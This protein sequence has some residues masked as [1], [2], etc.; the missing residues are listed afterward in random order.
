MS[1]YSQDQNGVA[2]QPSP[3]PAGLPPADL[4][5]SAFSL[6]LGFSPA[7]G[8]SD[9]AFEAF[10]AYLELG[11]RRRYA[12]VGTK[13]GASLRT[14]K[15]WAADFNWRGRIN[16]HSAQGAA[17]SAQTE[18]AAHRGEI[19]DASARAQA[20]R[21]RQYALAEAILDVAGRYLE[22]V[23]DDDLDR[24]SFADACRALDFAS[25]L[26][27]HAGESG[28]GAAP[29]HSL[30]DQLAALLDQAC[31]EAAVPNAAASPLDHATPGQTQS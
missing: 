26:A 17:L 18:N 12:A 25:R 6:P 3:G 4:H 15:R 8:E 2:S 16:T 5:S 20:F 29:D 31:G 27:R 1:E 13:V 24:M 19:L 9:R 28:G 21:D 10:R 11:P 7:P 14:V 22:R 30:R 23:E